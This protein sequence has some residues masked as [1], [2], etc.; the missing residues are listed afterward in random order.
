MEDFR[1]GNFEV[2]QVL[3]RQIDAAA[4]RIFAHVANYIGQLEGDA[5]LFR[6]DSRGLIAIAENLNTD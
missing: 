6:I 4:R 2:R 5:E 3:E 1:L